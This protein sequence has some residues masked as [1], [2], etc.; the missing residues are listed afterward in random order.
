MNS[1]RTGKNTAR[2]FSVWELAEK[3]LLTT[4]SGRGSEN[5]R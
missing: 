3:R 4:P 5:I 2:E 1:L